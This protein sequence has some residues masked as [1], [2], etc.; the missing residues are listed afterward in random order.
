LRLIAKLIS[1][2]P[3]LTWVATCPDGAD[4]VKVFHGPMV[5]TGPDWCVEA[6]WAG[7]FEAADFDRTDLVFGSGIR[8]RGDKVVFASSGS[9]LDRLWYCRRDNAWSVSNS[10]PAL[11]AVA[12]VRLRNDY[13]AYADDMSSVR[14]GLAGLIRIFPTDAGE[15][16]LVYFNNLVLED[17]RLTEVDKPDAA[18]P[19][20][21]YEGYT[22]FLVDT[23][24]RLATNMTDSKRK[25][26][27]APLVTLS[28]GYD[29]T[30]TAVIA[31]RAG[32]RQAVTIRQSTSFWRGADTGSE[33]A[34]Y[35]DL[36]CKVHNRTAL[37]YPL[38]SSI[39]AVVGRPGVLN[40]TLF[41][42]P[43]PLCFLF[44]GCHG[45]KVWDRKHRDFPDPFVIPSVADLGIGEF[46]L[47]KGVMHCPVPFW[48]MRHWREVEQISFR[49]EM[50]PWT[51]HTNYDRPIPR[52]LIE[53]ADVPRGTFAVRKKNTSHEAPFLWPYSRDAKKSFAAYLKK[54]GVRVPS[55]ALVWFLRHV[56]HIDQLLSENL[57]ARVRLDF[58]LRY[59]MKFEAN[60]LLFHW[61]NEELR[62]CYADGLEPGG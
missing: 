9:T 49:E 19:F 6:V 27:V 30:A 61:A 53:E 13:Y 31:R 2:W 54:Q 34:R 41:E 8:L 35:L 47:F 52:R 33:I 60:S 22:A 18:P 42:Y 21:T 12:G 28:S 17:D 40:W 51:L 50:E 23:A 32:C 20:K 46:R 48:G 37:D 25:T 24:D 26:P 55:R 29:S 38:E 15:V 16:R 39:W 44:T 3:K 62:Q 36:S 10:L 11:L 1:R 45:D 5:E 4:A 14:G 59:K 56:A 58:K 43:E 7:P 57:L